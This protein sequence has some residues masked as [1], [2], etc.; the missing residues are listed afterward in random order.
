MIMKLLDLKTRFRF[1]PIF[2]L[3]DL[4]PFTMHSPHELVQLNH[5]VKDG[6]VI[7]IARG[8]YTLPEHDRGV[9]L[10]PLWLANNLYSPSYISLEYALSYYGLIPEAVGTITSITTHKTAVFSTPVGNFS[11]RHLKN[12][13]F[14]GFTTVKLPGTDYEFWMATAEKAVIDFIHLCIPRKSLSDSSLFTQGYRFQNLEVVNRDIFR[15]MA[16]RFS[17]KTTKRY[18]DVFNK[19]FDREIVHD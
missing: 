12:K 6:H 16:D 18:F 14:F 11:Y 19:L 4:H 8:V 10:N 9:E 15:E 7:R 13:D 5:W 17:V 3:A 1:R 2:R